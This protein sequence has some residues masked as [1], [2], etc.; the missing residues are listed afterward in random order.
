MA[1]RLLLIEDGVT[2]CARA[3][4]LPSPSDEAAADSLLRFTRSRPTCRRVDWLRLAG[5]TGV[6][7]VDYDGFVRLTTEYEKSQSWL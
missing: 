6:E 2:R 7:L 3:A 5:S 1:A 4:P